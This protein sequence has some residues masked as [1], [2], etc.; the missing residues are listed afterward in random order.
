MPGLLAKLFSHATGAHY[1]RNVVNNYRDNEDQL[2][3]R[4]I[5]EWSAL[6]VVSSL[7]ASISFTV[8]VNEVP[9]SS[10]RSD[11]WYQCFGIS[12]GLA[13]AAFFTSVFLYSLNLVSLNTLAKQRVRPY[14]MRTIHLLAMPT[15]TLLLGSVAMA[16]T[17]FAW[18]M[19]AYTPLVAWCYF[20]FVIFFGGMF[21]LNGL[22]GIILR[23]FCSQRLAE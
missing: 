12:S 18:A 5:V 11:A 2:R 14:L 22:Y 15:F 9:D 3:K 1:Y 8:F 13:C 20:A 10:L 19:V 4:L 23:I 21:V 16:L 7:M 6:G 17:G